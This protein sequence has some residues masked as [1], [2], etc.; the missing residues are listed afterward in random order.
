MNE[1]YLARLTEIADL[2]SDFMHLEKTERD[3][4]LKLMARKN[5]TIEILEAI[6]EKSLTYEEIAEIVGCSETS[7]RLKL[8][9]LQKGG[10]PVNL[11]ET[12]A[13]LETGRPRKL[14]RINKLL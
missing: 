10:F 12:A 4:L 3:W 8:I 6:S 5:N 9:A 14:A 1:K 2:Y 13:I 11:T 7:V